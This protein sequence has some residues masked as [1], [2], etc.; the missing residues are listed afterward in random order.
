MKYSLVIRQHAV[1]DA[2]MVGI[3]RLD[4]LCVLGYLRGWFDFKGAEIKFLDGKKYVWLHAEQAI[5]DLPI[6]FN[7]NAKLSSHRNQLSGRIRKLRKLGLLDSKIIGRRLFFHL[8]DLAIKLTN[9]TKI[10]GNIIAKCPTT[11]TPLHDET[12]TS[13]KDGTITSIRDEY[14][15]TIIDETGIKDSGISETPPQSPKGDRVIG[16]GY[17][18]SNEEEIYAVYPKNVGKP[19]ALRAIRRSLAKYPFDFLLERTRLYAQTCNL[20]V[21]FIPNPATWFNQARFNDAPATWRRT[22]NASGKTQPA[23][24][25][26]DKFG[27][28]VS[29]L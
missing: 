4:G 27:C 3:V 14:L 12:V 21:Q 23:I 9:P 11:I 22:F 19:N 1:V 8:T 26:P 20:P 13:V 16:T 29:K 2:G 17:T 15:S 25:R 18:S 7:A 5:E 28:G 10:P 6:L 24:V